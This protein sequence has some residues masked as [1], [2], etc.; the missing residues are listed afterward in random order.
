MEYLLIIV[1]FFLLALFIK[2]KFKIK[3]YNSTKQAVIVTFSFL[4]IG[5]LADSFAVWRGYWSFH[6]PYVLNFTIGLLP[7]EEYLLFL[8]APFFGITVYKFFKKIIK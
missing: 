8:V 6:S 2:W 3:V 7:L 1:L 4:I 5:V